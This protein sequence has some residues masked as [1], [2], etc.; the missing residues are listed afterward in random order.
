MLLDLLQNVRFADV[1]DILIVSV[2]LYGLLVWLRRTASLTVLVGAPIVATIYI[3]AQTFQMYL[4]SM[5]FHGLFAVVLIGLII[6]FQDDLRRTLGRRSSWWFRSKEQPTASAAEILEFVQAIFDLAAA[7]IGAL[8]VLV[9]REPAD[10]HTEGGIRL[11]GRFSVPLLCSLFDPHSAGHDG[12]VIIEDW[13][14]K[15]FGAH[16]PLSKNLAHISGRGTRHSAA[17]GLSERTDALIIVVSEERGTVGVAEDGRLVTIGSQDELKNRIDRWLL[18]GHHRHLDTAKKAPQWSKNWAM[19]ILAF[20]LACIGWVLLAYQPE[21]VE[22]SFEV[23]IEYRNVAKELSLDGS[24]PVKAQVTLSGRES[25]FSVFEP[26]D[27]KVSLDL[28]RA[29]RGYGEVT[30]APRDIQHPPDLDV[31]RI[32]PQ[33]IRFRLVTQP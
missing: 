2:V 13:R 15:S 7:R 31:T 5:I 10:P 22:R 9:G 3:A 29:H 24:Q 19:K 18:I 16:L 1:V 20:V 21:V 28:T 33:K 23:P 26:D 14:V 11:G 4:T 32:E 30:V 8:I 12:A 25:A 17:L 6:L 27:L